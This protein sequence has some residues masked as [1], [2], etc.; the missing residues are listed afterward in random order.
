MENCARIVPAG[1]PA[2]LDRPNALRLD[3]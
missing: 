3:L 2:V 1:N